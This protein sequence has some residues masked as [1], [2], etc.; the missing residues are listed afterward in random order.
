LG[1]PPCRPNRWRPEDDKILGERPDAQVARLLG[2]TKVAVRARR[3]ELGIA[4][5]VTERRAPFWAEKEIRLLGKVP[6]VEAARLLGRTVN[7]VKLN[8]V[9]LGIPIQ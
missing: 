1:I 4:A 9:R 7:S 8:R 2:R 6:D 5:H 3:S